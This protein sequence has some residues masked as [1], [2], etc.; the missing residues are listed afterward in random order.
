MKNTVKT[1]SEIEKSKIRSKLYYMKNKDK[2]LEK[3]KSEYSI[4]KNEFSEYINQYARDYRV[5]NSDK[6]KKYQKEY[7]KKYRER[8]KLKNL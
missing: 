5:K 2:I 7:Q 8:K 3:R 1:Q 4:Y 6:V